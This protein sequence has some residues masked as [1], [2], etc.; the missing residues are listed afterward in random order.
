MH[1]CK[2]DVKTGLKNFLLDFEEGAINKEIRDIYRESGEV[3]LD[4]DVVLHLNQA[5]T[6]LLLK[7]PL[8]KDPASKEGSEATSSKGSKSTKNS[9]NMIKL[10]PIIEKV[11]LN[12][13]KEQL[14]WAK[15]QNIDFHSIPDPPKP[16]AVVRIKIPFEEVKEEEEEPEKPVKKSKKSDKRSKNNDSKI[17]SSKNESLVESEH[18]EGELD[19]SKEEKKEPVFREQEI[20][21]RVS[22]VNPIGEDYRIKVFHQAAGRVLRK[23]MAA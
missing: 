19:K 2:D 14:E 21:D 16:R 23:D 20:E 1:K 8:T 17:E 3:G 9:K 5:F 10:D 22:M 6:N 7:T 18:P 12:F 4:P 11:K 13:T 15:D